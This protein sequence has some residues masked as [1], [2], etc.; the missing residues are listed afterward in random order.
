MTL[1]HLL[2]GNHRFVHLIGGGGKTTLMYALA[3]ALRDRG[4]TVITTT[5]TRIYRPTPDQSPAVLLGYPSLDLLAETLRVHRHL[6]LAADEFPPAEP[7]SRVKLRGLA[8]DQLARLHKAR[9]AD[10]I[11]VEADGSAGRPIKG[12]AD[13]EPALCPGADAVVL[14]V[15][16][17]A[18]GAVLDERQIHRAMRVA[19]LLGRPLGSE[20][21][22]DD[23][24]AIVRDGYLARVPVNVAVSAFL[25]CVRREQLPTAEALATGLAAAIPRLHRIGIGD[26]SSGSASGWNPWREGSFPG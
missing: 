18:V 15:G 7:A 16:V 8:P 5:T 19:D 10:V 11:V 23:V 13:Y 9:V 17:D 21:G 14:V 2:I 1:D 24:V 3:A 25:T 4:R 12:H 6:T 22:V 20:L 26:L